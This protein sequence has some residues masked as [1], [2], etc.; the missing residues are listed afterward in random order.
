MIPMSIISYNL[1][2]G[3]EELLSR[4]TFSSLNYKLEIQKTKEESKRAEASSPFMPKPPGGN[5]KNKNN[6]PGP[7][8]G[9]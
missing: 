4:S 8:P 9:Q 2:G 3:V 6:N 5:S 7:P 1:G